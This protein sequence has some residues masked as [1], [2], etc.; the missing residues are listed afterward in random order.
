[1]R[2]AGTKTAPAMFFGSVC[3]PSMFWLI[4]LCAISSVSGKP[5]WIHILSSRFDA[6]PG[7]MDALGHEW[8]PNALHNFII[9]DL[10][11]WRSMHNWNGLK[12]DKFG[13]DNDMYQDF[14]NSHEWMALVYGI[15]NVIKQMYELPSTVPLVVLILC[16]YGKHRSVF[17]ASK[18]RE[19]LWHQMHCQ[20]WLT[21]AAKPIVEAMWDYERGLKQRDRQHW[22]FKDHVR[23]T[24]GVP[25]EKERFIMNLTYSLCNNQDSNNNYA[26]NVFR[27]TQNT[28]SK[29]MNNNS[30]PCKTWG[31]ICPSS[32]GVLSLHDVFHEIAHLRHNPLEKLLDHQASFTFRGLLWEEHQI[33]MRQKR[34]NSSLSSTVVSTRPVWEPEQE[35]PFKVAKVKKSVTF[36]PPEGQDVLIMN[37]STGC[38]LALIRQFTGP[39]SRKRHYA[40]ILWDAARD[41]VGGGRTL[42]V[43]L[44]TEMTPELSDASREQRHAMC[45][46]C[47]EAAALLRKPRREENLAEIIA[48]E[49]ED[50]AMLNCTGLKLAII[51]RINSMLISSTND[52]LLIET[53]FHAGTLR[54]ISLKVDELYFNIMASE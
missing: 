21:H 47:I 25:Q 37:E 18:V 54:H 33:F 8:Y 41:R 10:R 35:P 39:C 28:V 11:E 27:V 52:D 36:T 29:L 4:A 38:A 46:F 48:A 49:L 30:D 7:L 34:S 15:L 51:H 17:V 23:H 43:V 2:R 13:D 22:D 14:S 19:I 5:N 50:H 6:L 26:G 24:F 12:W 1:M 16:H 53:A 45:S 42:L 40:E 3:V 44:D 20:I 9:F 31:P 32:L